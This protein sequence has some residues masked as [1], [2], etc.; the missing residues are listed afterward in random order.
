MVWWTST[1]MNRAVG[2]DMNHDFD[3]DKDPEQRTDEEKLLIRHIVKGRVI[4]TEF[5][6][7]DFLIYLANNHALLGCWFA[8]RAHPFSRKERG[9]VLFCSLFLSFAIAVYSYRLGSDDNSTALLYAMLFSAATMFYSSAMKFFA[10]C[11]C[12][13]STEYENRVETAGYGFMVVG[14]VLSMTLLGLSI[15]K[16]P[17]KDGVK[18]GEFVG[19]FAL[20]TVASWVYGII[21]GFVLFL[22]FRWRNLRRRRREEDVTGGSDYYGAQANAGIR[23]DSV[24]KQHDDLEGDDIE[25]NDDIVMAAEPVAQPQ[26]VQPQPVQPQPVQQPM[27]QPL[28]QD[29]VTA[30]SQGSMMPV[31]LTLRSAHGKFVCVESSGQAVANRDQAQAWEQLT[32]TPIGNGLVTLRS[33]HG[34]YA[35]CEDSG[36][37]VVDRDAAQGWEHFRLHVAQSNMVALQSA[38]HGTFLSAQQ[39]GSLMCDRTEAQGWE[40]FR[41]AIVQQQQQLAAPMQYQPMQQQQAAPM[42]YQYQQPMQQQPMQQPMQMQ[43]QGAYNPYQQQQQPGSQQYY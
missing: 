33:V 13:Q 17:S 11:P 30:I 38:A 10:S 28:Q 24:V 9:V 22:L 21:I 6:P 8:H 20:T 39:D 42:Q 34:K 18:F 19:N 29:A 36:R 2:L 5:I 14:A 3:P 43:P 25:M 1:R 37:F 40:Y 32:V 27:Q 31:S 35:C 23:A 15:W 41:Y 4:W 16:F 7:F 26:P 12:V